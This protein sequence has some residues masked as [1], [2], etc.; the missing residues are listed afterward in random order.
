MEMESLMDVIIPNN[1][2][3]LQTICSCILAALS[4]VLTYWNTLHLRL[5]KVASEVIGMLMLLKNF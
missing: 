3:Y 1:L 4:N 5:P 2:H